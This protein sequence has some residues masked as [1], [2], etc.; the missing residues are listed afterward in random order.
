MY[1]SYTTVVELLTSNS[2]ALEMELLDSHKSSIFFSIMADESTDTASQEELSCVRW[3]HSNKPVE[4][5]LG[6]VHE[7]L[8]LKLLL[9]ISLLFF[10]H[11]CVILLG[12]CMVL[13]L[14]V[15]VPCLII[16]VVCRSDCDCFH[17]VLCIFTA[18]IISCNLLP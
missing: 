2:K 14:M 3:P 15:P 12:I 7:Q 8:M 4:H 16:K 13:G 18:A 5:F 1:E 11:S 6:M 10:L 17:Q 9:S